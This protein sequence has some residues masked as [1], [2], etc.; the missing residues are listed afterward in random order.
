MRQCHHRR[1]ALRQPAVGQLLA[2]M[3]QLLHVAAAG[4]PSAE[5]RRCHRTRRSV[6]VAGQ[7]MGQTPDSGFIK[8]GFL[9]PRVGQ[10][11]A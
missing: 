2:N 1:N 10:P 11:R 7:S 9:K 6:R 5:Q 8:P 3:L 4:Q